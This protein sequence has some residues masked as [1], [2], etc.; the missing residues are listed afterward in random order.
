MKKSNKAILL[1]H[2]IYGVNDH[3]KLMKEKL[4][5]LGA[6]IIC[7]NLLS[8]DISYSYEEEAIA[9]QNF[10]Q[11]IGIDEGSKQITNMLIQLKQEYEE[12]GIMGFS[13]GATISWL[14]SENNLCNFVI[15]CYGSRIRNYINRR[16]VCPTLLIFPTKEEAFNVDY[17]IN[18]LKQKR[19]P[20]LEVKKFHGFHGFMNPFSQ[21][22]NKESADQAFQSISDFLEKNLADN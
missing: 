11:N 10:V 17:L 6:D 1:I 3:M 12:V 5:K 7:P 22:F 13:V 15:G 2:E 4:S 18:S 8:R 21:T 19:E 9:Y 20:L 16:P 14:C